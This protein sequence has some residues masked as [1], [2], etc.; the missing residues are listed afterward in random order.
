MVERLVE[1]DAMRQHRRNQIPHLM[2]NPI[3]PG[4]PA[5]PPQP[6]KTNWWLWGCGGCLGLIVLGLIG[7]GAIFYGAM[8]II[9]GSESYQTAYAAAA[10]SPEVQAELGTPI[11][12]GF[13][14]QGNVNSS[15]LGDSATTT[16]DL[17]IPLKGPKGT[18]RLHYAASKSGG[19][20]DVSDLTVTIDGNGK[21]IQLKP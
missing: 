12:A 6:K 4:A 2:S 11:T 10:K 5:P 15:G 1:D 16:A 20:W 8:S 13:M 14:P 19:K 3:P 21:K 9:K 7:I 18:G 17:T